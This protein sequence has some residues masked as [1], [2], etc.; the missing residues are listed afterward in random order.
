MQGGACCNPCQYACQGSK[1]PAKE[2]ADAVAQ[3]HSKDA[4]N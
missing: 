3:K 1:C 2:L 4:E